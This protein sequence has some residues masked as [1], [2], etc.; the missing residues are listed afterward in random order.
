MTTYSLRWS[1]IDTEP[2]AECSDDSH[3]PGV[4]QLDCWLH[5]AARAT[6]ELSDPSGDVVDSLTINPRSPEE[7]EE[8]ATAETF[9]LEKHGLTRDQVS[10]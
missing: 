10:A 1:E 9:L 5:P 7:P 6:L 2:A 8:F 3:G 4:T